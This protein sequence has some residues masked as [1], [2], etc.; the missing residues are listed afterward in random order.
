MWD[1]WKEVEG[2]TDI[3]RL[4]ISIWKHIHGNIHLNTEGLLDHW[5]TVATIT[6]FNMTTDIVEVSIPTTTAFSLV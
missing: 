1:N 3:L 4:I 6:S 2:A 5:R